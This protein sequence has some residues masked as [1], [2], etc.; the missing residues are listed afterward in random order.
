MEISKNSGEFINLENAIKYTEGFQT[1]FPDEIN[2][3][4]VGA[5]KIKVLLEQDN[6]IGIRIY[7]GY[8]NQENKKNLVLIGVNTDNQDMTDGYIIERLIT[9]PPICDINSPLLI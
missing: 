5:E 1:K 3:Y 8:N 7:N 4:F 2:S 6:C 9:C